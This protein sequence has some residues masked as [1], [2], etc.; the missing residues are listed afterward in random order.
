MNHVLKLFV[1]TLLFLSIA[2]THSYAK[3]STEPI[4][5]DSCQFVIN[6]L[7]EPFSLAG[8]WQFTRGDHLENKEVNLDTSD[9]KL[10]NTPG[11]WKKAYADK[12]NF[13]VG[14]YRGVI[15]FAPE[16]INTEAVFLVDTY[17]A[18]THVYLDGEPIFERG[19]TKTGKRYFSV[20]PIPIRFKITQPR[21]VL[22]F[23]VDTVLMVGV[24]QLPFQIRKYQEHD[25]GLSFFHFWGGEFRQFS[26]HVILLFGLFFLLVYLKTRYSLYLIAA[27]SGI[28]VYPFYAAPGDVWITFFPPEQLLLLHY[29]GITT[30]AALHHYFCQFFYK[31][32]P[33][34]TWINGILVGIQACIF[35]YFLFDFRLDLFQKVRVIWFLHTFFL[36]MHIWY[37]LVRGL[38][39]KRAGAGIILFGEIIQV[40]AGAQDML[41]ALGEIESIALMFFGSLIAT[42]C[43]LWYCS[44]L[45]A[46][47]FLQN[48]KLLKDVQIMNE[49]LESS[50]ERLRQMD[51]LKDEFL[52][53]TSHELRTP[54]NG[55][56]GL[57]E[58]LLDGTGG[59]VNEI[60][61]ENMKMIIRSGKRLSSLVNDI[62]DFSKL[63]KHQL[64]LKLE[65]VDLKSAVDLILAISQPLA[66]P[67]GIKLINNVPESF[68]LAY[69]DDNRLQQILQNLIGN[70]IKFTNKGQVAVE[71]KEEG[72]RLRILIKDTGIGVRKELHQQ[73]FRSFEQGDGSTAREYG[74]TGLGLTITKQLVELHEGTVE[75]QSE[76]GV[77]STFSFTIA[78]SEN[79]APLTIKR[80]IPIATLAVPT[81]VSDTNPIE[82]QPE[83]KASASAEE[84]NATKDH[85]P[86][87]KTSHDK[88]KKKQR[89][90][91][92]VDD[93]PVN[94]Q[95]LKNQLSLKDYQV[96]SAADGFEALSILK[97][98]VPDLILLDLM[99]PRMS[100]YEVCT[101]I[102]ETFEGV[103]LPIIM[104]T[105]KNQV[106]DLVEGFRC[107][108][109]D[110]LTKPF[111]KEE[112]FARLQ[113]HIRVKEAAESMKEAERLGIEME[114]AQT[115]QEML[116]PESDPLLKDLEVASFYKSAAETGG[117]WYN[118][119]YDEK[120]NKLDLV[121]GDVTGH[122][123]PAALV[124]AMVESAYC[125]LDEQQQMALSMN[126]PSPF[127]MR[128]GYFLE[129]MNN[130]LCST[131]GKLYHMTMFYSLI[132]L[133]KKQLVYASA[134]HNPCLIW[135]PSGF[136]TDRGGKAVAKSMLDLSTRGSFIGHNPGLTY[137]VKTLD[138]KT[139]DVIIWYTDGLIENFNHHGEEFGIRRLRQII[140]SSEGRNAIQI[141][142]RIVENAFE[143]YG[144]VPPED[145]L[146]LVVA[147]VK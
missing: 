5:C 44:N 45:F 106:D 109:N 100:G 99:M 94:I 81:S 13:R 98:E 23:R 87:A 65:R 97:K 25:I 103:E 39:Q 15:E 64:E 102:R 143:F 105:A 6:S 124:T 35:I 33:K 52:A 42:I 24:Y 3:E 37:M 1:S 8:M 118:F 104:L 107:G 34:F 4:T 36:G 31:F 90:V 74:G 46:N 54:L 146:T 147:K 30:A 83:T 48:R 55:I 38:L 27:L 128:P 71:A 18:A 62:L 11:P 82:P 139:D 68:P 129:L 84:E 136:T 134:A 20:Q 133:Q 89:T 113:T 140:R 91:L 70:G 93:E 40:A 117:D 26:A 21:H 115:V 88:P 12:K 131:T 141:K 73:I 145:D 144:E 28:A 120:L 32:Y 95:V 41:L 127:L 130:I 101:K 126:Q 60:Q 119:R 56:I 17:M 79:Q 110:Y 22:T 112:L 7:E 92:V 122:G 76:V 51:K 123:I 72:H 69:V 142:D 111:Q 43:I 47:T 49:D 57:T 16:L 59:E 77:G 50:N 121:I 2:V 63:Q 61:A 108:A 125:A 14:W 137:E 138:L 66:A 78:R 75:V 116:I 67:K 86:I 19:N 10:V 29:L 80:V 132:D 53:N 58:S 9:W 135:R 85:K 114:T 96:L